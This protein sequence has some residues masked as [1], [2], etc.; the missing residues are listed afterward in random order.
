MIDRFQSPNIVR[1]FVEGN[2]NFYG[3]AYVASLI[4]RKPRFKDH[5][6]VV[7]K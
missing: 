2:T 3:D 5:I 4:L 7:R 6:V 1:I